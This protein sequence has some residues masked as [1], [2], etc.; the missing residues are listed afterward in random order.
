MNFEFSQDDKDRLIIKLKKYM[1]KELNFDIGGF[2]A[3]FF[4]EFIAKELAP[5]IY[6]KGL[7][8]AQTIVLEKLETINEAIDEQKYFE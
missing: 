3:E 8:D 7:D 2:E 4:L 6:N 5:A 1:S